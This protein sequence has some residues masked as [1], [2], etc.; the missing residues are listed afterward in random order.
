M[1]PYPVGSG[2]E[3][4]W[5]CL[6]I[7]SLLLL[8]SAGESELPPERGAATSLLTLPPG[9]CSSKTS[10]ILSLSFLFQV[11]H[12]SFGFSLCGKQNAHCNESVHANF[13]VSDLWPAMLS[14]RGTLCTFVVEG[15][16]SLSVVIIFWS[17]SYT[18]GF[19]EQPPKFLYHLHYRAGVTYILQ[20]PATFWN[21]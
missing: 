18:H 10:F 11:R 13:C 14:R 16:L 21:I 2:E 20:S 15:Q 12:F 6:A 4:A 8:C 3:G 19:F 7:S 5:W 1:R 9:L 17:Y